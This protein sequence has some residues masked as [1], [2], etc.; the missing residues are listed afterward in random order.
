[1]KPGA[2]VVFDGDG[3]NAAFEGDKGKDQPMVRNDLLPNYAP[4]A[5]DHYVELKRVTGKKNNFNLFSMLQKAKYKDRLNQRK[6]V[7]DCLSI[8]REM[9]YTNSQLRMRALRIQKN[10][11]ALINNLDLKNPSIMESN[12]QS[13]TIYARKRGNKQ[14]I[15]NSSK[16]YPALFPKQ[17]KVNSSNV[18]LNQ[19]RVSEMPQRILEEKDKLTAK[20]L[21][22]SKDVLKSTLKFIEQ[23]ML[24]PSKSKQ[25]QN[26]SMILD[27]L[28]EQNKTGRIIFDFQQTPSKNISLLVSPNTSKSVDR[29]AADTAK[30]NLENIA[31]EREKKERNRLRGLDQTM[32]LEGKPADAE[33]GIQIYSRLGDLYEK[34]TLQNYPD[35]LS[36]DEVLDL[37]Y[38]KRDKIKQFFMEKN[39]IIQ[40]DSTRSLGP[41]RTLPRDPSKEILESALHKAERSKIKKLDL[42]LSRTST[43]QDTFDRLATLLKSK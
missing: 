2:T 31:M 11:Q 4:I 8:D 40:T 33:T 16:M 25:S 20:K 41:P 29:E 19:S 22:E 23:N 1:M 32:K 38:R 35:L 13:G 5:S 14:K 42:S 6:V 7:S 43:A 10:S 36:I 12:M 27:S 18:S 3:V 17:T 39:K 37:R 28:L 15:N 21:Q 30:K 9:A 26:D 24:S 34:I